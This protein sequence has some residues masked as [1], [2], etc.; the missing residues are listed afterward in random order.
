MDSLSDEASPIDDKIVINVILSTIVGVFTF[1]QT[2]N[3]IN[4]QKRRKIRRK[5]ADA[6]IKPHSIAQIHMQLTISNAGTRN[7]HSKMV[8]FR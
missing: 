4:K 2:L 5:K 1:R 3:D 6:W 7:A 8:Y